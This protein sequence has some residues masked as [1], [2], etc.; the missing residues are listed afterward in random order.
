MP[1]VR[2]DE[3]WQGFGAADQ[4]TGRN[5][6]YDRAYGRRLERRQHAC[7]D[8]E[9]QVF[10]VAYAVGTTL[11]DA[12]LVVETLDEAE[13]N[14]VLGPT[15]GRNAVPM[16]VDHL[17]EL[18][19]RLESLPL[20]AGAPILK[21]A[22]CP[23]LALVAPQFAKTLLEDIGRVEPLVGRQQ[24]LQRL[25]TLKREVLLARQQRVFLTF[26]IAPLAALKPGILALA[27]K[28]RFRRDGR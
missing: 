17:G 4:S 15:V 3:Y 14:L 21:E 10:F 28:C 13:R 27:N 20:E 5:A 2:T 16:S 1:D 7:E 9:S 22:S 24:Y 6:N 25:L 26:Y 19:I 18:L 23:T 8:L 11:D 12:Y